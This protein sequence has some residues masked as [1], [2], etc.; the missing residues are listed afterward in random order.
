MKPTDI[1]I[2]FPQPPVNCF[3][4]KRFPS[5]G[6]VYNLGENEV[7]IKKRHNLF[8]EIEVTKK[9]SRTKIV[10]IA[11]LHDAISKK[12]GRWLW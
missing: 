5:I 4:A 2:G 6:E 9:K 12:D 8:Y 7:T 11:D 10:S 3:K 1:K